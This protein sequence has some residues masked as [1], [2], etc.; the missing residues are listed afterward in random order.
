MGRLR[1]IPRTAAFAWST[2]VSQTLLATGTRAGAVNADFSDE[3]K[4]EIWDLETKSS[5]GSEVKP[6]AS[7]TTDSR[8]VIRSYVLSDACIY[9]KG[10]CIA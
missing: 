2:G 6:V 5:E 1:E 7:L 9:L 10:L 4:L 3:T 8:Y